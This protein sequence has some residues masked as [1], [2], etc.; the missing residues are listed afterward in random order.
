MR[1]I[2][3]L[4][5]FSVY[6]ALNSADVLADC[7]QQRAF[8]Q[9]AGKDVDNWD[10]KPGEMHKITLPKGTQ[11]GLL[12]APA[13][14][15]KYRELLKKTGEKEFPELVEISIF[16]LSRATPT[17]LS[18]TWGGANSLQGY[19]SLGGAAIDVMFIKP[20]CVKLEDL[21]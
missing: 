7:Q 10:V 3:T 17:L 13:T 12:I 4:A 2:L 5:V 21:K 11:L 20:N 15:D 16:D 18:H 1:S 9:S 6:L 8:V 14:A 19:G